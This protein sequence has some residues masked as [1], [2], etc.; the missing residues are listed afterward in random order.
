MNI[1]KAKT[2][3]LTGVLEMN[4]AALPHVSSVCLSDMERYLEQADPFLVI[5][6]DGELS[7]FMIVLQK[8]LD[9]ESLN[10]QFFCNNY[11]S[12]DYVDR[13]VIG[14]KFRGQKL[15]TGLYSYLFQE[16]DK[17]MITCEVNLRPP[18]P[19]SLAFHK[20][21]GFNKVAEQETEGG[22][23]SVAMMIKRL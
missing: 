23:K 6:K 16:S 3:D 11:E 1:R 14:E 20:S 22:K 8:G 18:N 9:Y 5:E 21:L 13:I 10:Y 7:G 12:F 19:G 15:G 2:S 4:E 17:K